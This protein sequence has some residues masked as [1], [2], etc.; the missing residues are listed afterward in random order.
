MKQV[1][2]AGTT[3]VTPQAAG[4]NQRFSTLDA[5]EVGIWGPREDSLEGDFF[6]TALV[7]TSFEGGTADDGS[8]DVTMGQAVLLKPQFQLVQGMPAGS[9]PIASPIINAS[10]VQKIQYISYTASAKGTAA[11]NMSGKTAGA[12]D[13]ISFRF[14]VKFD[15]DVSV[16]DAQINGTAS[17]LGLGHYNNRVIPFEYELATGT[18]DTEGASL[19]TEINNSVIGNFATAAYNTGTDTITLTA[20]S[21]GTIIEI[22]NLTQD[23]GDF[24]AS[25][26][27]SAQSLVTNTVPTVGAGNS[28]QVL[29][30]EK[31]AR[32]SQGNFNRMYFPDNYTSYADS[33][34]DYDQVRIT[35]RNNLSPNVF[36]GGNA[37]LNELVF[38]W[39]D[40][41]HDSTLWD[42]V[43]AC[44]AA[45][46][47]AS[48]TITH[49]INS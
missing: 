46:Q 16:Y 39:K 21:E 43:F 7:Q 15:G 48:G 2:V 41:A 5:G 12:G 27:A 32:Y 37:G 8:D 34:T 11:I 14:L 31:Q 20:N 19:A 6:A 49:F 38:Y 17:K 26:G 25:E 18:L 3:F 22:I 1:F 30:E 33:S 9:N 29:S 45:M 28:H 4:S 36:H 42:T 24:L 23:E 35:Y 44:N 10:Q 40:T 47:A 13:R